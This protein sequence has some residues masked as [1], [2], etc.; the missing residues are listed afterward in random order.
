NY[1]RL[2]SFSF[3]TLSGWNG[4]HKRRYRRDLFSCKMSSVTMRGGEKEINPFIEHGKLRNVIV[5]SQ[6]VSRGLIMEIRKGIT[7]NS[8]LDNLQMEPLLVS[9]YR[10]NVEE[11]SIDY[12]FIR[13]VIHGAK[14]LKI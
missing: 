9:S 8:P 14:C 3:F 11:A 12:D 13:D 10:N 1:S 2:P 7:R 4:R 5:Q 6:S